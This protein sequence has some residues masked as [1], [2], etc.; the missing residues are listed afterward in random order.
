MQKE[1]KGLILNLAETEHKP[2]VRIPRVVGRRPN[3]VKPQTTAIAR[4]AEDV[5]EAI[6]VRNLLH[7]DT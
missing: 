1:E 3:E 6:G 2:V 7:A 5:R 4:E